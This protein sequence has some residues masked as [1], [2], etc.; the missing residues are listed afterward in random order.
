MFSR[1]NR[2]C[3]WKLN[4]KWKGRPSSGNRSDSAKPR[5]NTALASLLR[6]V[7]YV[8]SGFKEMKERTNE[9]RWFLGSL[10][11]DC[12]VFS[13]TKRV[14]PFGLEKGMIYTRQRGGTGP[15]NLRFAVGGTACALLMIVQ[16]PEA[17]GEL[18]RFWTSQK[19]WLPAFGLRPSW[20]RSIILEDGPRPSEAT[21][22]W[23]SL[24]GALRASPQEL[25]LWPWFVWAR[26]AVLG[27]LSCWA[28]L[29]LWKLAVILP[30]GVTFCT[31]ISD[32]LAGKGKS[33]REL[34]FV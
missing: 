21:G 1:D 31:I 30:F 5:I 22:E 20:S 19:G 16:G 32:K 25:S 3:C 17:L 24:P 34:G 28:Q 33:S 26:R 18:T 2:C 4:N 7:L 14:L 23:L 6:W 15:D 10:F 27:F 13:P 8:S 12:L 11:D 9:R 29:T